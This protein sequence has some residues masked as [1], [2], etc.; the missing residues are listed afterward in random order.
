MAIE[1]GDAVY[2]ASIEDPALRSRIDDGE[3]FQKGDAL[4]CRIRVVETQRGDRSTLSEP[5]CA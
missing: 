1:R 2:T 3:S 5:L 4:R